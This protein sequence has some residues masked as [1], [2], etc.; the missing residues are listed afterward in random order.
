MLHPTMLDDVG[1]SCWLRLNRPL[2]TRCRIYMRILT[3]SEVINSNL[4]GLQA[5]SIQF[6]RK[7]KIC[8]LDKYVIRTPFTR[9]RQ[10][11]KTERNPHG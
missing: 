8:D 4:P 11:L 1:P 7:M 10:S 6:Y 3:D 2:S 9:C 5:A